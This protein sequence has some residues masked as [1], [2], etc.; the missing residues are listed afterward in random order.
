MWRLTRRRTK[1]STILTAYCVAPKIAV[2]LT[3][4]VYKHLINIP[5]YHLQCANKHAVNDKGQ[6]IEQRQPPV[7][8]NLFYNCKIMKDWKWLLAAV[9]L[10]VVMVGVV[11][12]SSMKE[13][14][15]VYCPYKKKPLEC[16]VTP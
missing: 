9:A 5:K 11:V 16:F 8:S 7:L 2:L 1:D 15:I 4:F 13:G 14:M 3:L 12:N 6:S 10:V